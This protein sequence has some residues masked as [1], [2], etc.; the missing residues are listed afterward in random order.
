MALAAADAPD[1]PLLAEAVAAFGAVIAA[2]GEANSPEAQTWLA[3]AQR[4]HSEEQER[5]AEIERVDL[6][7]EVSYTAS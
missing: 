2:N 1:L 3:L 4:K 7:Q 6:E 5:Q